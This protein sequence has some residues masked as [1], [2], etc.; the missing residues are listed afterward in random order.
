MASVNT[1]EEQALL[2]A[3]VAAI[4]YCKEKEKIY[5]VLLSGEIKEADKMLTEITNSY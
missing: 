2:E 3:N 4:T 1:P 5:Y